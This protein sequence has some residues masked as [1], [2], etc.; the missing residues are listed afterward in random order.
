MFVVE[1]LTPSRHSLSL[2]FSLYR[3]YYS[4]SIGNLQEALEDLH[5]V[6]EITGKSKSSFWL[7][8]VY[9]SHCSFLKWSLF[10]IHRIYSTYRRRNSLCNFKNNTSNLRYISR[11]GEWKQ[12]SH[13]CDEYFSTLRSTTEQQKLIRI[14][15][16]SLDINPSVLQRIGLDHDSLRGK[17]INQYKSIA[18]YFCRFAILKFTY[19][20]KSTILI[21]YYTGTSGL[22]KNTPLVKFIR[23]YIQ[24]L[25]EWRIDCEQ[26]LFKSKIGAGRTQTKNRRVDQ[27]W[28]LKP[29]AAPGDLV[30]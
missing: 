13:I 11:L 29:R 3:P 18:F 16:L 30:T 5:C 22:L 8:F 10:C 1:R 21:Y 12:F 9:I 27:R 17:K 23:N 7:S 4:L 28:A 15:V 26:S 24:Q 2:D 6:E 14:F 20:C 19:L 25:P